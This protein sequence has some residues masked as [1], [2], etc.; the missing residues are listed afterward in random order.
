M[1]LSSKIKKRRTSLSLPNVIE[2]AERQ[3]I[4]LCWEYLNRTADEI[5][6]RGFRRSEIKA[7]L[8]SLIARLEASDTR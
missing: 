7:Q 1:R 6:Y 2:L 3:R 4:L 5:G 8:H